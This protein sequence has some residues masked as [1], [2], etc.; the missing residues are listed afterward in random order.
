[1]WKVI[2]F[3][4]LNIKVQNIKSCMIQMP[5][6]SKYKGWAF[7]HPRKLVREVGGKGYWLSLSYTDEWIFTLTKN[8]NKK[9]ISV[10][11]LEEAFESSDNSIR[12][13]DNTSYLEVIEPTR[14]NKEVTIND[15]LKR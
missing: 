3:N 13:Y 8:G 2:R 6:S 14:I 15:S 4:A 9:T 7:W 10:A 1:M 5:N 12:A 11:A